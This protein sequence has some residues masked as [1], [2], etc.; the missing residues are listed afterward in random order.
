MRCR[1]DTRRRTDHTLYAEG[2]AIRQY[3]DIADKKVERCKKIWSYRKK[4][5]LLHLSNVLLITAVI[6]I[7]T[8]T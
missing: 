4:Y 2:V 5:V 8:R 7:I 6:Q 3:G 1:D